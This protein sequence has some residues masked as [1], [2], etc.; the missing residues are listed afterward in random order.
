MWNAVVLWLA[1]LAGDPMTASLVRVRNPASTTC[2]FLEQE[3]LSTMLVIEW[4]QE[5]DSRENEIN[6]ELPSVQTKM[7]ITTHK[8][9]ININDFRLYS[10][11][12][13]Y[14][15]LVQTAPRP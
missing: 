7:K 14:F 10:K 2:C 15:E 8:S 4:S 1:H 3:F 5:T 12:V 9:E 6:S 13:P 11:S